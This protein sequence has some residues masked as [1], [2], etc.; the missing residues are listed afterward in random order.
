[1]TRRDCKMSSTLSSDNKGIAGQRVHVTFGGSNAN[2]V[3]K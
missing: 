3:D 2:P 1:M